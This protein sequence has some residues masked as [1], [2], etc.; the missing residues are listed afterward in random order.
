MKSEYLITTTQ[1]ISYV[2]NKKN[3]SKLEKIISEHYAFYKTLPELKE[4]S[5]DD[6]LEEE[7][8]ISIFYDYVKP[9]L[10][11]IYGK[12]RSPPIIISKY[13][14][15][16]IG[17]IPMTA[18]FFAAAILF[19]FGL[20]LFG[21]MAAFTG[22]WYSDSKFQFT[23]SYVWL[24]IRGKKS[25]F[26][27]IILKKQPL[28]KNRY[29]MAIAL[30]HEY[31]HHYAHNEGIEN[32]ILLEAIARKGELI[33]GK[34][35]YKETKNPYFVKSFLKNQ[36]AE[37]KAVYLSSCELNKVSPKKEIES[38]PIEAKTIEEHAFGTA[39]YSLKDLE[40]KSNAQSEKEK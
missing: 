13:L 18:S 30:A 34:E 19:Y 11:A 33:L 40:E 22:F 16:N 10:D 35:L 32:Y 24:K 4:K 20:P 36:I 9:K 28:C 21:A 29:E 38:I 1:I 31:L 2:F 14:E 37:L 15:K 3:I 7:K 26:K 12:F 17:F 23:T 6:F 5:K 8:A 39:Y 27:A 25:Y